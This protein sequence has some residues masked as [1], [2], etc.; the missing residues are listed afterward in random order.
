LQ[1]ESYGKEY[2]PNYAGK[3]CNS[4]AVLVISGLFVDAAA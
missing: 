1:I 2:M 4:L 3:L